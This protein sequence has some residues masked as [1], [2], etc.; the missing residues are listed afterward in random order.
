[1]NESGITSAPI[2]SAYARFLEQLSDEAFWQLAVEAAHAVPA[3]QTPVE[4][5]LLCKLVQGCCILPL[6]ALHEIVSPPYQLTRF[7]AAPAWMIG[8]AA[9]RGEIIAVVDVAAYLLDEA[10]PP[11]SDHA[12]GTLLIAQAGSLTLGLFLSAVETTTSLSLERLVPLEQA[13][14]VVASWYA[15][16]RAR[17]IQGALADALVLNVPA[18][19]DDAMQQIKGDFSR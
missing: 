4:G 11:P 1:M 15:P 7:P 16:S 10:A 9:W 12:D 17:V 5:Y 3:P 13:S 2:G 14:E 19:L 6:A 8:L 18:L